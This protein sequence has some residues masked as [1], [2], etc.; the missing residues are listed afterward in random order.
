MAAQAKPA[1]RRIVPEQI[2]SPTKSQVDTESL[3]TA[4]GPQLELGDLK[5]HSAVATELIGA[6]RKVY[7]DLAAYQRGEKEV[8][9]KELLKERGIKIDK[10]AP[11]PQPEGD[12]SPGNLRGGLSGRGD[13]I[14][15]LAAVIQR[16]ERA[17]GMGNI[18]VEDS[19][20]D[21]L[22]RVG[23]ADGSS[24]SEDEN[25]ASDGGGAGGGNREKEKPPA[26]GAPEN[27]QPTEEGDTAQPTGQQPPNKPSAKREFAN[28]YDYCDD[29]ID[30]TEFIDMLEHTDRRKLKYSGFFIA[31]GS[32]DRLDE[33]VPGAI[34]DKPTRKRKVDSA[35]AAAGTAAGPEGGQKIGDGGVGVAGVGGS[36]EPAKKK[37]KKADGSAAAT[38]ASGSAP[39]KEIPPYAMPADVAAA[40]EHLRGIAATVP[41]P[42]P[43]GP[44]EGKVNRKVLPPII[45]SA[46]KN[47]EHLFQRDF[48]VYQVNASKIITDR[49]FEFLE[50]FST[51][52]N[53]R[54]YVRGRQVRKPKAKPAIMSLDQ[55]EFLLAS[56]VP[57]PSAPSAPAVEMGSDDDFKPKSSQE[58]TH[59]GTAAGPVN[60]KAVPAQARK[61]A[62]GYIKA[63]IPGGS[64][65]NS[66][67]GQQIVHQVVALFPPGT[68]DVNGLKAIFTE[69]R[70]REQQQEAAKAA[71][72]STAAAG[73]AAPG[74]SAPPSAI[75]A[76]KATPQPSVGATTPLPADGNGNG[77]NSAKPAP[78]VQAQVQPPTSLAAAAA[79][80]GAAAAAAAAAGTGAVAN[81]PPP[82]TAED[83]RPAPAPAAVVHIEGPSTAPPSTAEDASAAAGGNNGSGSFSDDEL[84]ATGLSHGGDESA[85]RHLLQLASTCGMYQRVMI[86]TL[87]LAGPSGISVADMASNAVNLGMETWDPTSS[88]VKNGLS[89]QTK[90][91]SVA[92][93]AGYKYALKCFP[94]VVDTKPERLGGK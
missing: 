78:A 27:D 87:I 9:W 47:V 60:W 58:Q 49:L 64:D 24:D 3:K 23:M 16:L 56:T 48:A 86:R 59:N 55:L 70:S 10:R 90:H 44:E 29:F 72:A 15:P 51:R 50:P 66:P 8:D 14:N 91:E 46:V 81:T 18:D 94:G 68:M 93:L 63:N 40:I 20:D 39:K 80:A 53:I 17:V 74:S 83:I 12:G 41:P 11:I 28:D 76:P 6:G 75:T 52:E 26:I 65:L 61:A 5:E 19:D 71:Q 31:R 92:V 69:Q 38:T 85:L 30:D 34:P 42:P 79:A 36:D 73:A 54:T 45:Y 7:I 89:R 67:A 37:K 13:A 43:P 57:P 33:L 22:P 4:T 32:I 82:S 2:L 25:E 1:R 35:A 77:N 88:N 62:Y 21:S 84:L